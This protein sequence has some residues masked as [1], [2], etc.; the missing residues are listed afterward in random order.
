MNSN[1]EILDDIDKVTI[2]ARNDSKISEKLFWLQ[3]IDYMGWKNLVAFRI[4]KSEILEDFEIKIADVE[5]EHSR[6]ENL[7]GFISFASCILLIIGCLC[8]AFKQF[9]IRA[10]KKRKPGMVWLIWY[11]SYGMTHI[12]WLIMTFW[13]DLVLPNSCE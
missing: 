3:Y 13:D 12:I 8:S 4:G 7:I 6:Q 5:L 2:G 10:R 11:D 9:L 1:V